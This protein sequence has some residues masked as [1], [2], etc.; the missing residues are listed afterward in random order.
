M[1]EAR[2]DNV[3]GASGNTRSP[4][5]HYREE[6]FNSCRG[7][8][9]S[10][11][12]LTDALL[13]VPGPVCCPAHLSLEAEVGHGALYKALVRGTID[14]TA[15]KSVQLG[16]FT[17]LGLSPVFTVDCTSIARPD[18][19]T[20]P[21]RHMSRYAQRCHL[22]ARRGRLAGWSYQV[23]CAQVPGHNSWNL[24]IEV[25]RVG[26]GSDKENAA[27]ESMA[28]I[29]EEL[30]RHC[31]FVFDAGYSSAQLTFLARARGL[32]VTILVRLSSYQVM[33]EAPAPAPVTKGRPPAY[34]PRFELKDGGERRDAD[35][36]FTWTEESYGEVTVNLTTG[37]RMKATRQ[38]SPWLGPSKVDGVSVPIPKT[39]GDVLE[40]V[41]EKMPGS[42]KGGRL[43]LWS[44]TS[45]EGVDLTGVQS[46]VRAYFH[47]FDIEHM[48]RF[49]KQ[50]LG[51]GEYSCQQPGSFDTWFTVV[52]V[53]FTQLLLARRDVAD[54][55]LP[56]ERPRTHLTPGRVR[57]GVKRP[58][59]DS[60]HPPRRSFIPPGGPGALKGRAQ[61][62]RT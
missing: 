50:T 39:D 51:L 2:K 24:P 8:G 42:S 43:W 36:G 26:L 17:H 25:T 47:R 18:S 56:W 54:L 30:G 32:D 29:S 60:F 53:A 23:I 28:Q 16:L 44:S 46:L 5:D 1:L 37:L 10:L 12:E 38:K 14:T 45:L 55:R 11:F 22:G 48:F 35:E 15:L 58:L 4:L 49:L 20:S 57:R 59:H 31:I 3:K 33:Y 34:G 7:Y 19:P 61:R 21:E 40:V 52:L 13:T 9:T 27:T 6:F 41:V 62:P